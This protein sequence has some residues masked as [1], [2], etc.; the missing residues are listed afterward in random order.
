[1]HE[2]TLM[3]GVALKILRGELKVQTKQ[4]GATFYDGTKAVAGVGSRFKDGRSKMG[5]T[6]NKQYFQTLTSKL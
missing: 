4:D 6:I 2:D 3:E 1:M 5:A